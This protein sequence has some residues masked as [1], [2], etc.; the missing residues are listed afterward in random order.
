MPPLDRILARRRRAVAAKAALFVVALALGVIGIVQARPS[1]HRERGVVELA[2]GAM[3]DIRSFRMEMTIE[4]RSGVDDAAPYVLTQQ[5]VFSPNGYRATSN[6]GELRRETRVIDGIAYLRLPP[7]AV[8]GVGATTPWVAAPVD[9]R[10]DSW[11]DGL[12]VSSPADHLRGLAGIDVQAEYIGDA[13]VRGV[14]TNHYRVTLTGAQ[15]RRYL[16]EN[17]SEPPDADATVEIGIWI[18]DDNLVRRYQRLDSRSNADGDPATTKITV[19][20]FD[21]DADI[22]AIEAPPEDEVTVFGSVEELQS[23]LRTSRV[24]TQI[25]LSAAVRTHYCPAHQSLADSVANLSP[26]PK[27]RQT[28]DV[29]LHQLSQAIQASD[30]SDSAARA[31]RSELEGLERNTRILRS[32]MEIN[33][34]KAMESAAAAINDH[35][36]RL[37]HNCA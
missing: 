37:A 5:T 20:V 28:V 4:S 24:E 33:G 7:E 9:D 14:A 23:W 8:G 10:S 18:D 26:T 32:S 30:G 36:A 22:A 29:A 25:D 27:A 3:A 21:T 17:S 35:L 15:A 1:E 6:A 16:T 12:R 31:A 13:N 11:A 2:A 19:E 34:R